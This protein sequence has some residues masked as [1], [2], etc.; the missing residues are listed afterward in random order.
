LGIKEGAFLEL[1]VAGDA[2]VLK[3]KDLW[4]EL[5]EKGNGVKFDVDA[6]E[7]ELDGVEE[8]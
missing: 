2:L 5:R 6:F 4:A 7:R 3:V 8:E 1:D